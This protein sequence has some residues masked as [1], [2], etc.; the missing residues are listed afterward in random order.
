MPKVSSTTSAGSLHDADE[1]RAFVSGPELDDGERSESAPRRRPEAFA[2]HVQ[3]ARQILAAHPEVKELMGHDWRTA[4]AI[5]ALV[6]LQFGIGFAVAPLPWWA[7]A[8]IGW[9]FGAVIAHALGVSIH[10]L[11]HDLVFERRWMNRAYSI[12]A[13]L[14]LGFP[15]AID[16]RDKHLRHHR[17]LGDTRGEDTQAPTPVQERF[18]GTSWWRRAL[19]LTFGPLVFHGK[20]S[21]DRRPLSYWGW[22]AANVVCCVALWPIIWLYSP[23]MFVYLGTSA[24]LA[25]GVHP[26]GIRRYAEHVA[27]VPGQPTSSYYGFWNR[28]SFNVGYHVEHHDFPGIPWTRIGRLREIAPEHYEPLAKVHSWTRMLLRFLFDRDFGVGR[29]ADAHFIERYE[30]AER[31]ERASR[32]A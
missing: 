19:W 1:D 24:L 13:N 22:V 9:V 11:A 30:K 5:A 31:D 7:A 32:A 15:A 14:P 16:F 10:E 29:Y 26:V 4:V 12:F 21:Q 25:F 6:V 28:L 23:S 8:L 17:W 27:L 3:R 18:A 20:P 2:W